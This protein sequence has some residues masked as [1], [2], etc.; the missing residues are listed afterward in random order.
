MAL[1]RSSPIRKRL[2]PRF[3]VPLASYEASRP[4]NHVQHLG[5]RSVGVFSGTS[6]PATMH[7]TCHV[8]RMSSLS[9]F[10]CGQLRPR[11][12]MRQAIGLHVLGGIARRTDRQSWP[13]GGTFCQVGRGGTK[14]FFWGS[15]PVC[16]P[17]RQLAA[18]RAGLR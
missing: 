7:A 12:P 5:E 9:A 6:W 10:H 8:L 15:L 4:G 2:H 17:L 13:S 11:Q 14:P 16:S 18:Y 3:T 1:M